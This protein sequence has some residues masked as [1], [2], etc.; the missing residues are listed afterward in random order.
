MLLLLLQLQK[1][2]RKIQYLIQQIS[3]FRFHNLEQFLKYLQS[4]SL[5]RI[6]LFMIPSLLGCSAWFCRWTL[7][8]EHIDAK[9]DLK[10]HWFRVHWKIMK[11]SSILINKRMK[12]TIKMMKLMIK[13]IFLHQVDD[14]LMKIDRDLMPLWLLTV[15]MQEF[16]MLL[17][18]SKI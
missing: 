15:A 11:N 6:L 1:W 10:T 12:S 4:L 2:E 18:W 16:C 14:I 7:L 9:S 13:D 3:E 8:K 17:Y 5:T